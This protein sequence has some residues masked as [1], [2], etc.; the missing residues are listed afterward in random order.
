MSRADWN[1]KTFMKGASILT[2]SAIIVKLLGAV[3]RVPFQNLVG[4]KGFYIY[5]QVYPFIGIFI[6][7]TSYGFA[8]AVSNYLLEAKVMANRERMMRIAFIYL[9]LL[10]IIVFY[11]T[12]TVSP[13]FSHG[14]WAIHNLS[15]FFVRVLISFSLMPALAVLKGSFQ[16]EGQMVPVAVSGVGEQAFRVVVILVGTWIAVRA[17]ASF[18]QQVKW[19]CGVRLLG[20]SPVSS[21]WRFIFGIDLKDL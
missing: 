3:Y 8:V 18:I 14:R 6:V 10:S 15:L 1:M 2:I 20:K 4:D 19:P 21:F 11:F 9:L 7:W 13:R 12:Y 17:G 16:S 5:Q